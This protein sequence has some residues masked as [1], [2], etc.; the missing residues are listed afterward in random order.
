ML[1]TLHL[2]SVMCQLYLNK[3]R[4]KKK[5][6][7]PK[8]LKN[9]VDPV[10][11]GNFKLLG[12]LKPEP[13]FF[14]ITTGAVNY[15]L[16]AVKDLCVFCCCCCFH[17]SSTVLIYFFKRWNEMLVWGHLLIPNQTVSILFSPWWSHFIDP[18]NSCKCLDF[19]LLCQLFF[20]LQ[21]IFIIVL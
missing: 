7:F 6:N 1:Y 8:I 14:F 19:P 10:L 9:Q 2:H 18:L 3:A 15:Y 16:G 11:R 5:S 4:E 20:S 13:I 21:V 12:C 17:L